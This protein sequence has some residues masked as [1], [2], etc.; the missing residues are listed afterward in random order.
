MSEDELN[1]ARQKCLKAFAST[2]LANR[3]VQRNRKP[4]FV[5]LISISQEAQNRIAVLK[6]I[7]QIAAEDPEI[8]RMLGDMYNFDAVIESL[9]ER[10]HNDGEGGH[11]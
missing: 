3:W 5:L 1:E 9:C 10:G 2:R 7:R 6:S 4:L 11:L 8:G